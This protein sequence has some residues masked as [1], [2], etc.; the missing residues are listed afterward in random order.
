MGKSENNNKPADEVKS[1]TLMNFLEACKRKW[2][3]FLLS[4]IIFSGIGVVSVMTEE[5]QYLRKMQVL[6]KDQDSGSG[7][8]GEISNSFSQMGLVSSNTNVYNELYTML[9]PAVMY[10]VVG[11][12]NLTMDYTL[13]HFPYNITLYGSNLPVIVT[14]ADVASED[15]AGFV[16]E[17]NPDGS[18]LLREFWKSDGNGV[19]KFEQT[20]RMSKGADRVKT[21]IGNV[22]VTPNLK[23]NQP[24]YS[25]TEEITISKSGY[26]STTESY[27]DKLKGDLTDRDADIID[28]SM[29]DVSIERAD[30]ILDAVLAVYT[31]KWI[32]DKNK[33]AKA[34]SRFIDE[35]LGVIQRELGDVDE[36]IKDYSTTNNVLDVEDN[37]SQNMRQTM[38]ISK[39]LI[40]TESMLQLAKYV[41]DFVR[42]PENRYE[43]IPM[44]TGIM[45]NV[46][47]G[48]IRDYNAMLLARNNLVKESS[49]SNPLITDYDRTLMG[50]RASIEQALETQVRSLQANVN[51]LE[52]NM[53][54][55][56]G[57]IEKAPE[58]ATYLVGVGRQQKVK[59]ELY[60]YL[61]QKR[62]ENE[63]SQSF[64]ADNTRVITP[65]TGALK[66]VSPKK[67]VTVGLMFLLGLIL[68]AAIVYV[69]ESANTKVRS[70]KD[71][72]HMAT[73]M[74]G[75][76][77][78][79]GKKN[80][81]AWLKKLFQKKQTGRKSLETVPARV[82]PGS[83]DLINE[84]FR[85]VRG[86]IDFMMRNSSDKVMMITS[87][88]P[89]SGKSF[90]TYNLA[91][92]FAIKGKRVLIIDCDLRHGSASQF[93]G[94]PGRGITS[95]LTNNVAD[96]QKLVV[97]D[98][99]LPELQILP[100][101]HR[102]PNPAEL[103]ELPRMKQLVEEAKAEYDYVFLDCPPVDIVVDTQ[104]LSPLVDRTI[105]VVRA[106]LLDKSQINEIDELYH[107]V[108]FKQMSI[109][110][111]GTEQQFSKYGAD[112]RGYYGSSYAVK[113]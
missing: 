46:F 67:K 74:L 12:L 33:I 90:I 2:K 78:M 28:L 3:W 44:N 49:L 27:T 110:L 9:S 101:G 86:N 6:V 42:K 87:F 45:S 97:V 22:I 47:D 30:D 72:E 83:R 20:V 43:V 14:M 40:E 54:K 48:E 59:E 16:M 4:I 99:E 19:E 88:N 31:G 106:G 82:S 37:T 63:L 60:L 112:G 55:L 96:W 36:Q 107:L 95:Y 1:F 66:P 53:S 89:G 92:S 75:E 91:A 73:P 23:Y 13:K 29:K 64:T 84:S 68:P 108:R 58:Q 57:N 80:R 15:E 38:E 17:M 100:I 50:M 85:I 62:E 102:P 109:L 98:K 81:M 70:R 52:S 10:Q 56:Q 24:A 25:K 32:S 77:P 111:N 51:L 113:E 69:R 21:P 76:I 41:R 61:L 18:K 5:P 35:R 93:I 7:G 34:T 8:I 11:D 79:V 26:L 39:N 71:L 105:F 65:P 104:V 94:M 103:L